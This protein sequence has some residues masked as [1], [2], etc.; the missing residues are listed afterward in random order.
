MV[1]YRDTPTSLPPMY[2]AGRSLAEAG[3][4]VEALCLAEGGAAARLEEHAPAFG[5]RRFRLRARELFHAVFGQATNLRAVAALQY[6]T[7]YTEYVIKAAV[8]AFR[9]RA[10]L[11]EAND[12]PALLPALLA[13]K[14]RRRPVVYRAH[15]LWPEAQAK[16]R[17]AR[18]WRSLERTLVPFCAEVVTPDEDRSAIYNE[19]LGARR[20]PVTV[21]NCPPLRPR[22]EST[23]L[24]DELARRGV[25][26]STIVLYQGLIDSMRCIEEIVEGSRRFDEGVVLVILGSGF[27][28]WAAPAERLAS[29]DR[30][31]VLPKVPYDEV[32]AYTAS[33]DVGVMLYRNDCRNNYLCA[34]NKLFEYMMMGLPVIAPRFPGMVRLVE[35]KGVGI[36]VDPHEPAEIAAAVNAL[37]A[38]AERRARMR[39]NGLRLARERYN[40]EN[41]FQPLL[42]CYRSLL[43]AR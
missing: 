37:A 39:A 17:F 43:A 15:E 38:D 24:R 42:R 35:G 8:L 28:P 7:S 1:T 30:I 5:T 16:V 10:D 40:W 14:A 9:A 6:L 41:E 4:Q 22:V 27:G 29:H 12:L 34:P 36:C 3:F 2:H 23:R 32:P 20:P 11:I 18:F 25:T 21:H 19:E 26:F 33:A 13:G 31:V